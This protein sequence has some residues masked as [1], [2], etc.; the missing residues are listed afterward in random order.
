MHLLTYL[1]TSKALRYGTRSQGISY[2]MMRARSSRSTASNTA[3][4]GRRWQAIS[5]CAT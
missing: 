1:L 3:S 5:I 4:R 2:T